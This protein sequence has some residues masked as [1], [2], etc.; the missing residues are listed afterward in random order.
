MRQGRAKAAL[1]GL[2]SPT[3]LPCQ[4]DT[5]V[6]LYELLPEAPFFLECN[7]FTSPDPHKVSDQVLSP[8]FS[9]PRWHYMAPPPSCGYTGKYRGVWDVLSGSHKLNL[10]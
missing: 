7:S 5:R 8:W 1:A 2:L 10:Y 3:Y 4:G 6:F 9:F